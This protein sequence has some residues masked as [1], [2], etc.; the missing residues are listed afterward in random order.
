MLADLDRLMRDRSVEAV[1]IPMHEAM[2]ASFRWIT[3]GAKVTRGYAVKCAGRDPILITY[4]M[5]RDEARA[6]GLETHLVHEF[7]FDRIFR[8]A[9]SA[10]EAYAEFFDKVL[11]SL[12]A[13]SSVAFFGN[14][15]IHLYL[16]IVSA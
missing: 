10:A 15:P 3:R 12:G 2:H 13:S 16:P 11:R 1:I 8:S 4:P 14:L 9:T 5:E 7:D 6:S